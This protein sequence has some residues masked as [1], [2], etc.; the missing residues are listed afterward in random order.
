MSSRRREATHAGSWYSSS[1]TKLASELS[2]YLSKVA[3]LPELDYA[4]PVSN[5]KAIIAPHAG[6]SYSGPTA[7][8]AYAAIP[9]DK[10]KRV[11]LLGPSHHAYLSGVALSRF[12]SYET[13]VGDL[14]LDLE[15]IADLRETGVFSE[16]KSSVDEEEHSLE[17]HLPYIRHVFNG[18]EDLKLVP[19]L[20][21]HPDR[22][23]L[24]KLN[25]VLARYWDDKE[26]FFVISSDFCHW[27]TRFSCTPYYPNAPHPPNPV[28]P[29]PHHTNPASFTPPDLI[30][31]F[32]SAEANPDVPIWKSIEYMD[33]EGME[34]LR[35][36]GEEGAVEKWEAY[37]DETKNTICGRNPITVLLSLVQHVYK[38]KERKPEFTFVRYEQSSR[39]LNGRDSSVSYVS[40]VLRIPE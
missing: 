12:E 9:T 21:G 37:L 14:P 8:W 4:P 2:L 13:P 38:G 33:H 32:S 15:A 27:G 5:A 23:T 6:Y 40:G 30:K 16:M 22:N 35:R 7:G 18:R 39:C 25:E 28:P 10:I 1:G 20:V 36:P 24:K 29:V 31:R 19:I 3:P 34:L 17:M 26:T 11:F